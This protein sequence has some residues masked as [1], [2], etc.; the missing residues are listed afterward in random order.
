[1]ERLEEPSLSVPHLRMC[2]LII[3]EESDME[4]LLFDLLTGISIQHPVVRKPDPVAIALTDQS[5]CYQ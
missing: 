5:Q 4:I 1:M 3:S 2:C